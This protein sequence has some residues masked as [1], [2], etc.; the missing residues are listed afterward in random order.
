[1]GSGLGSMSKLTNRMGGGSG[2]VGG[3]LGVLQGEGEI[4]KDLIWGLLMAEMQ[5]EPNFD[6]QLFFF[7]FYSPGFLPVEKFTYFPASPNPHLK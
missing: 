5:D 7:F 6:L 4:G 1:M 3:C 2:A